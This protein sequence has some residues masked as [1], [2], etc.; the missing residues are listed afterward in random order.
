ME[1]QEPHVGVKN[2]VPKIIRFFNIKD[3][4]FNMF[5]I[6]FEFIQSLLGSQRIDRTSTILSGFK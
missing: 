1:N 2:G 5:L 3:K 4:Y 6:Q